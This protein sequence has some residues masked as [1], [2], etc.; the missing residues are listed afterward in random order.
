MTADDL[1]TKE[2]ALR[3][4]GRVLAIARIERDALSPRAAAEAAWYPG[5][6][7]TVDQIEA[8]IIRQRAQ[9]VAAQQAQQTPP[10]AA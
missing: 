3:A 2:E 8:L 1:P 4:G 6:R 9:A 7:L 10:L 5:H